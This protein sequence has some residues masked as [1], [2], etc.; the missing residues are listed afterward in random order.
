[1]NAIEQ[2]RNKRVTILR[3]IQ[4]IKQSL[5]D[6]GDIPNWV[7]SDTLKKMSLEVARLTHCIEQETSK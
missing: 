1:M 4:G 7:R 6:G 3:D 2:L 5:E